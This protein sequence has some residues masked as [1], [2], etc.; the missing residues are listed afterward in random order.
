MLLHNVFTEKLTS[1]TTTLCAQNFVVLRQL[2][3]VVV[4]RL[5]KIVCY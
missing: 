5:T 1:V 3:F 4:D 2:H